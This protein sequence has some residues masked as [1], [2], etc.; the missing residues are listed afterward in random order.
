[1]AVKMHEALG[2]P[3]T[4]PRPELTVRTAVQKTRIAAVTMAYNEAVF[5]PVWRRHYGAA[6]GEHNLFVLD[7]GSNDGST[8][9]LGAVNRVRVP[10]AILMRTSARHSSAGFTQA[11]SATT[12]R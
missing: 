1:M 8:D 5:L 10:V 12:T 7:H 9:R 3:I 6:V 4:Q 11:C 2:D